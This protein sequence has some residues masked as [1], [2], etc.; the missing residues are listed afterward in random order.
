MVPI[1]SLCLHEELID[2]RETRYILAHP[3]NF[4]ADLGLLLNRW[5]SLYGIPKLLNLEQ[6]P[7]QAYCELQREL[8]DAYLSHINA[9]RLVDIVNAEFYSEAASQANRLL[10][11][12]TAARDAQSSWSYVPQRRHT[13]AHLKDL[14]GPEDFHAG[15]FPP[16]APIWLFERR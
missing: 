14:L 3:E 1:Q 2:P 8:A 5:S 6:L 9:R 10:D 4:E 13:L 12:W 7:S 15:R 16:A 11:I